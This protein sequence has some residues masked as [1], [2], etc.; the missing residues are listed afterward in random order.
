[1]GISVIGGGS[2]G[3]G[4][5][6]PFGAADLLASGFV[7]GLTYDYTASVPA[8][9]YIIEGSTQDGASP[10]VAYAPNSNTTAIAYPGK[11]AILNVTATESVIKLSAMPVIGKP[12]LGS[13]SPSDYGTYDHQITGGAQNTDA[14]IAVQGLTFYDGSNNKTHLYVTTN[15]GSSWTQALSLTSDGLT[16]AIFIPS[17]NIWLASFTGLNN[18]YRSTNG[19]SWSYAASIGTPNDFDWDASGNI[20]AATSSGFWRSTNGGSTWTQVHTSGSPRTVTYLSDSGTWIGANGSFRFVSSNGTSWTQI[21]Y[22]D[23]TNNLAIQQYTQ[24]A[25]LKN[26]GVTT[27]RFQLSTTHRASGFIRIGTEGRNTQIVT[28][29]PGGNT[30]NWSSGADTGQPELAWM[31]KNYENRGF[32]L[33]IGIGSGAL[34][35]SVDG[36]SWFLVGG[37]SSSTTNKFQKSQFT[38]PKLTN[39]LIVPTSQGG[40]FARYTNSFAYKIYTSS[41]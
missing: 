17:L 15:N 12:L 11:S 8:G 22:N 21:Q 34:G 5:A 41:I 2:A 35:M 1:M 37:V 33:A 23:P 38:G 7:N 25:K 4:A 14:S 39:E 3:G 27:G 20:I 26:A 30:V 40:T 36:L 16:D 29:T 13:P 32:I 10:I 28:L 6:L 19:T 24:L 31:V 9:R 18:V